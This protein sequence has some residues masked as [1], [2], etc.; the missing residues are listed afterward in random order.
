MMDQE[1]LPVHPVLVVDD[2]PEIL[3]SFELALR[4]GGVRHVLC[5]QDS[6]EVLPLLARQEV[7]AVLLDL[8]MPHLTGEQ[9]L[10]TVASEYPET[11]VIV[12]TGNDDVDTAV[13]CMK[14]GAFDYMVKPVEKSRLVSGVKRALELRHL[15]N[16]NALLKEGIFSDSV[17]NP[18]AFSHI[19]T[20]SRAMRTVFQYVESI[21]PSPQPVLIT[22]ETGV[23]KELMARAIHTLS[24][25]K[26]LFVTVNVAGIDDNVFAD[27][28]FGHVKGAFTGAD[29]VRRGLVENASGGTLLLD[30]IGD[31]RPEAQVKLLRLLQEREYF[32]LGSDLPK[33]T[34]ARVIVT[35]NRDL[36]GL[37]KEGHFRKDLYYR[38][39]SHHIH[40]PPLRERMEDLPLLVEHFLE[41]A[42]LDLDKRK[43][44][45]PPELITVLSNYRFP[46]NVRELHAMVYDALGSH[47]SRKL[48]VKR[49][50]AHMDL[51]FRSCRG[52]A[53]VPPCAASGWY[54]GAGALPT[55]KQAHGLLIVE[56]LK[57]TNNN[58]SLAA[59][60]L[61]ISRQRL[62]RHLK[63][64][65]EDDPSSG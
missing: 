59:R 54:V 50:E 42:S 24:R 52:R 45:Y 62:A 55:L 57:R 15:Q 40:I 2:E 36:Q 60:M 11:P 35:T 53:V 48:S 22:G 26:G 65:G 38:L 23:G 27:T 28:L 32:P 64:E 14:S 58:Q 13:R 6:R 37:Q 56:A 3:R 21:A 9:I 5:C 47:E 30:E 61:G 41:K 16:E 49:F 44:A 18:E 33:T 1:L 63:A 20:N 10:S 39:G 17:R 46:G 19:V 51:E 8:T 34:D 31:L 4:S 7:D 43:P 29:T 12:I 25:R